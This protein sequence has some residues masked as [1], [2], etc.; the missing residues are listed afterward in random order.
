MKSIISTITAAMIVTASFAGAALGEGDY[1]NGT[2]KA[3]A[4]SRADASI[5]KVHTGSIEQTHGDN[6]GARQPI[7]GHTSRD[8]R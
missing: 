4:T 8:N 5:D 2:A 1:Y 7:F 6:Q 3:Q